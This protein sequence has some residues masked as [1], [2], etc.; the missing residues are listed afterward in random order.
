MGN[1]STLFYDFFRHLLAC[2]V[3]G[4]V[5]WHA[6]ALRKKIVSIFVN[7]HLGKMYLRKKISKNIYIFFIL[8]QNKG[9]TFLIYSFKGIQRQKMK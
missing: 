8:I 5:A 4:I 6:F 7:I 1:C 2:S 9:I 3:N